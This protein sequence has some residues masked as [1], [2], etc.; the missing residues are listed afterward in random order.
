MHQPQAHHPPQRTPASRQRPGTLKAAIAIAVVT[1]LATIANGITLLTNANDL[2]A[3]P[4]AKT[5]PTVSH[6]G[7]I[8]NHSVLGD[9]GGFMIVI[10]AAVVLF[11]ALMY[12][13]ATWTRIV[14]TISVVG[15]SG[16][17]GIVALDMNATIA[18]ILGWVATFTAIGTITLTWQA[19]N[20]R[21]AKTRKP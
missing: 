5:L 15:A 8:L 7:N 11:A 12:N 18:T 2:E 1:G 20:S 9:L 13:A 4:T 21:Y 14:V 16:V 17:S 19:P 10:G 3:R 6:N